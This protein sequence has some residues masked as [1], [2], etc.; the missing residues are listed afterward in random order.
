MKLQALFPRRKSAEEI[1][2]TADLAALLKGFSIE[3]TPRS[4]ANVE[5]LSDLLPIGTTVYVAHLS[6]TPFDEMLSGPAPVLFRS[7]ESD[8]LIKGDRI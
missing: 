6:G 7:S 5:A 3:V 2:P 8:A 1:A 4:L